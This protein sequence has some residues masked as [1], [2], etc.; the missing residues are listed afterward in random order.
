MVLAD[1]SLGQRAD[2]NLV[3]QLSTPFGMLLCHN[4]CPAPGRYLI[5]S[6]GRQAAPQVSLPWYDCLDQ[7]NHRPFQWMQAVAKLAYIVK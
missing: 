4:E 3:S 6:G 7:H 5:P 1:Q 2:P